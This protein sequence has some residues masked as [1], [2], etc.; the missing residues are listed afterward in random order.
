MKLRFV[1]L[2]SDPA[3]NLN[4]SEDGT[5]LNVEYNIFSREDFDIFSF[6]RYL[7]TRPCSRVAPQLLSSF[8]DLLGDSG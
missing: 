8:N 1:L 4:I 2:E 5:F 3:V 7:T 6:E